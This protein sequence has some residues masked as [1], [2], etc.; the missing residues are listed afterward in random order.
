[1]TYVTNE[2]LSICGNQYKTD[3]RIDKIIYR[4]V[5]FILCM[6]PAELIH[7]QLVFL[8]MCF[9]YFSFQMI[10]TKTKPSQDL[11]IKIF[12]KLSLNGELNQFSN[13]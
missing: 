5:D 1:M 8:S 11:N 6:F 4:F 3:E 13:Y 10:N 2:L 9:N 12:V 7:V